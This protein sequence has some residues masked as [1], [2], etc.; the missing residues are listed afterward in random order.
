M[1]F[2]RDSSRNLIQDLEFFVDTPTTGPRVASRHAPRA[3]R[4]PTICLRFSQ[5]SPCGR[6]CAT[7]VSSHE[8]CRFPLHTKPLPSGAR[9]DHDAALISR[10]RSISYREFSRFLASLHASQISKRTSSTFSS[11][12]SRFLVP[13]SPNNVRFE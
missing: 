1:R 10:S 11:F 9:C 7:R 4:N 8:S 2:S 5:L 12:L 3:W 6:K 13:F